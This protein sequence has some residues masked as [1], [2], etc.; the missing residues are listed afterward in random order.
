MK[1]A[2]VE[3]WYNKA[4]EKYLFKFWFAPETSWIGTSAKS[5]EEGLASLEDRWPGI[6][7]ILEEKADV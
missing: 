7:F 6:K 4:I 1:E 5:V 2:K 3:Y